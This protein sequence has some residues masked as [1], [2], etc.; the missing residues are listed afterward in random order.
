VRALRQA[1]ITQTGPRP[2]KESMQIL[3]HKVR[4]GIARRMAAKLAILWSRLLTP[5]SP[6][7]R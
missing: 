7:R 4:E 3:G 6:T 2:E 1:R 5:L